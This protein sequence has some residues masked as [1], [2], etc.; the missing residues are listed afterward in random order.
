MPI[1]IVSDNTTQIHHDLP[2][3]QYLK[4]KNTHYCK[5]LITAIDFVMKEFSSVSG[6]NDDELSFYE[7]MP[8]IKTLDVGFFAINTNSKTF[9]LYQVTNKDYGWI[10]QNLKKK[11]SKVKSMM[12]YELPKYPIK[13]KI[14]HYRSEEQ[15]EEGNKEET[16][17]NEEELIMPQVTITDS[18][19]QSTSVKALPTLERTEKDNKQLVM[20]TIKDYLNRIDSVYG[21]DNKIAVACEL[22]DYI[23]DNWKVLIVH[24]NFVKAI[25]NKLIEFYHIENA[26][27]FGEYYKKIF[28]KEIPPK[29]KLE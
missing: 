21:R 5:S 1:Y 6:V 8:D 17:E 4:Q 11:A 27:V 12:I 18:P 19:S 7:E 29:I 22:F 23:H 10:R 14:T 13:E 16:E 9:D 26:T 25:E 3:D 24:P 28:L 2:L 20:S 15:S